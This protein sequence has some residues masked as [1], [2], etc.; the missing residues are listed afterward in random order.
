MKDKCKMKGSFLI[1]VR[2][3]ANGRLLRVWR[4][5]NML[6]KLNQDVRAAM[7]MDSDTYA[8]DALA[9][10]YFAFGTGTTAPTVNDTQLEAEVYRK[11]VTQISRPSAANVQ[12]ILSLLASECNVTIREIGVFCGPAA[13]A[14]A[15]SG[16]L[17]SRVS[18]NI[19]KNSNIVLNV[20]RTDICTI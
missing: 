7:L 9:I 18:V 17:L 6:T 10:K 4:L 2:D 14:A 3:A 15:N 13:T 16:N 11:Q 20:T 8:A 19:E 12:S 5:D 1:E